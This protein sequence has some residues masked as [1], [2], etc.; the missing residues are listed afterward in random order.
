M[1]GVV[2]LVLT[3]FGTEWHLSS[4][5]GILDVLV[6]LVLVTAFT[7]SSMVSSLVGILDVLVFLATACTFSSMV[8]SM[9]QART[10]RGGTGV[11]CPPSGIKRSP[12]V[13]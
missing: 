13:A 2:V 8:S 7:F 5:V 1:L 10:Q 4:L 12:P 9:L 6:L 3:E 11:L